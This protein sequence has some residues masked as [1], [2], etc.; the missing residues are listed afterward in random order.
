MAR[1]YPYDVFDDGLEEDTSGKAEQT[2]RGSSQEIAEKMIRND[3]YWEG[4]LENMENDP[5]NWLAKECEVYSIGNANP[6]YEADN[7]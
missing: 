3:N 2:L 7:E 5:M 6:N 4:I 1:L